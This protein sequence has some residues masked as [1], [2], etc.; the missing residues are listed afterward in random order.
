MARSRKHEIGVGILVLVAGGLLAYMSLQVGALRNLGDQV[1][2]TVEMGDAAGL[3]DGAAVR[4]AGVQVGQVTEMG[5]QHD[6]AI[7]T[8]SVERAAQIRE[9][10]TVQV[11]ARSILG[12]KYLQITPR[13][14]DTRLL[15]DGDQLTVRLAQ[16]EIDELVNTLGPIVEAVDAEAIG[17]TMDRLAQ[18]LQD[19]PDR[20]VRMLQDLDPSLQ[21]AAAASQEL[22]VVMSE[23]RATLRQIR[24]A[25]QETRPL[26]ARSERILTRL[27]SASEEIPEVTSEVK[28]LVQDTRALVKDSQVAL[29]RIERISGDMEVVMKNLKEIDK[30]EL[31]RLLR[32]EGILLRVR[33][34]EVQETD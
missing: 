16:T 17:E 15:V 1:V 3:S 21:N 10:A 33:R 11:R 31:R 7:V 32:E 27:D 9:D 26:I 14:V 25:A 19:D 22:P 30:W 6:K 29:K 8:M 5:V 4:I 23:S 2:L 20:L 28:L 18:A 24:T 12:E 13:S 34:S